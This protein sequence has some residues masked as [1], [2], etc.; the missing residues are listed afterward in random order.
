MPFSFQQ[1]SVALVF[2]HFHLLDG[3]LIEFQESCF[4]SSA[5]FKSGMKNISARSMRMYCGQVGG[6][7]A[8]FLY[9]C[10]SVFSMMPLCTQRYITIL[11]FV[12]Q[13]ISMC[14]ADSWSI[15]N[16]SGRLLSSDS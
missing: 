16:S 6:L 14:M 7:Y 4:Y 15:V 2:K 10:L 3:Y 11:T 13:P 8:I 9:L 1:L 12:L 5:K